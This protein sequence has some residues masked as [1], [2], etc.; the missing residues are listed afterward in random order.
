MMLPY[1]ATALLVLVTAYSAIATFRQ[2]LD[3]NASTRIFPNA[4][5]RS[6]Q[7]AVGIGTLA[8]LLGVA[9]WVTIDARHSIRHSSRFLIPKGYVGWVRVEFQV[10]DAAPLP[11]EGGEYLFKFPPSG[12]LVTSSSEEYG[13]AKDHYFYYSEKGTRVLP[14]AGPGNL[15]WGKINGEASGS[16]GK[17]KYEEFFVGTEQQFREQI[18]EKQKVG[19][20]APAASVK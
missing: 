17:R 13:W 6:T 5:K 7:I 8:I 18:S 14:D 11:V 15:I 9:A 19:S 20:S 2:T 1:L 12:L 4:A 16:Q 3:G 10:N